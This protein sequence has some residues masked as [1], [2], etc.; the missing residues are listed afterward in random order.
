MTR[1]RSSRDM[2]RARWLLVVL[3]GTFIACATPAESPRFPRPDRPV[4]PIVTS[5][6]ATEDERDRR[7][8]AARVMDRLGV[9]PGLRVADVGAGDGYYTVRL[10]RRLAPGTTIY[11]QDVKARYLSSLEKR[12]QREGITGVTLVHGTPRDP[13]LP[14]ASID[15]AI[16]AHMYHEIEHPYEFLYRLVAALADGA[17]VAIIDIDRQTHDHGTPPALLRCELAAV[18]YRQVDFMSLA[19]A[20]GYLAVF[21]LPRTL[22][23]PETIVRCPSERGGSR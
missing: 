4:A 15:L 7:G 2:T 9:R 3:A 6:Y 11:A 23:A 19:P 8:E 18:G 21:A 12:L 17:R 20:D 5:A 14:A 16:L 22:A 13:R 1:L 10:A